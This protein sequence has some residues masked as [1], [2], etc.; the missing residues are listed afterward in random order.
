MHRVLPAITRVTRVL[1]DMV[2]AVTGAFVSA[3]YATIVRRLGLSPSQD[4]DG[5]GFII[6]QLDG[7]SPDH[8]RRA[9]ADGFAPNIGRLLRG[10]EFVLDDWSVG[11]PCTTPSSQA[12]I[13]YGQNDDIPSYRWY[14]KRRGQAVECSSVRDV[15]ELQ[16]RLSSGAT[17]ILRG[18]SSFMNM[19]DGDAS[20]SMFTLGSLDGQSFFH[21]V[22]GVGMLLLFALN[23][24]RTLK[25]AILSVWEYLTDV[26]QQTLARLSPRGPRP[27]SLRFRFMRIMSNVVLR[28][29]QT[30]AVLI[31][32]YRGV[33]AIYTTYY[34]YDELA[35]NYGAASRQAF[36]AIHAIDS[37]IRQIDQM[38][39]RPFSRGYDIYVLS[40]HGMTDATP[41]RIS[42]G[43]T[44]G[45]IVRQAAGSAVA[46]SESETTSRTVGFHSLYLQRELAAIE[47]NY[48]P[49]L[50]AL[51]HAIRKIVAER[52]A[53]LTDHPD[54]GS[55]RNEIV[56]QNSGPICHV[57]CCDK[58]RPYDLSEIV[59]RYPQMM[60]TILG[61]PAVGLVVAREGDRTI[62]AARGGSLTIRSDGRAV[63]GV[64]P[65]AFHS[66]PER[67][68][69]ALH[70]LAHFRHSG[71]MILFGQYD[72]SADRVV[73]FEDQWACH[74]GIGGDQERAFMLMP[75]ACRVDLS[76]V[77]QSVQIHALFARTPSA[78]VSLEE[79]D[80]ML[81]LAVGSP[82]SDGRHPQTDRRDAD[83]PETRSAGSTAC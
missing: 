17:G 31:D 7:L 41:I 47:G 74:G 27:M 15:H 81:A 68:A 65:L 49:P 83:A 2:G 71:D 19:F 4:S 18:G 20:L 57:Y 78:S 52:A 54:N 48:R 69:R 1:L 43:R 8:L 34:G 37:R 51:P 72:P 59:S 25:T 42:Y 30:F 10:K 29:I 39:R 44:L 22:R 28:E 32:I 73:C 36:R 61:H 9:I 79:S 6:I 38:R 76:S 53:A 75:A 46:L 5:T 14:D 35:H 23:P 16:E 66:A 67:V 26:V 21:G 33:P 63:E 58:V 3:K 12:G 11:L 40:D 56:L 77:E 64:D 80:G 70:R 24:Y 82:V 45:E 50:S 13:M 55:D 62:V 60:A